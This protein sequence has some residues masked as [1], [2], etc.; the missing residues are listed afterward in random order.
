MTLAN[1]LKHRSERGL[2]MIQGTYLLTVLFAVLVGVGCVEENDAPSTTL[3]SKAE[4]AAGKS[5]DTTQ[6]CTDHGFEADCNICKEAKWYGDGKC[7]EFCQGYDPD[8]YTFDPTVDAIKYHCREWVHGSDLDVVIADRA[9]VGVFEEEPWPDGTT[10][11]LTLGGT[12]DEGVYEDA[13]LLD[14]SANEIVCDYGVGEEVRVNLDLKYS[15]GCDTLWDK[16][17]LSFYLD[18]TYDAGLFSSPV[19]ITCVLTRMHR[20]NDC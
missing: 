1:P 19:E 6:I 15:E 3:P 12:W 14:V 17:E 10:R 11:D 8:C 4:V 16:T 2:K 18:A 9:S 20:V 7:D 5:D 13:C